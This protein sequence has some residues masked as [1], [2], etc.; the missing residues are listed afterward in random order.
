M[1]LSVAWWVAV[2]DGRVRTGWGAC[3]RAGGEARHW[4]CGGA[5]ASTAPALLGLLG[6]F[7]LSGI[8]DYTCKFKE[9]GLMSVEM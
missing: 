1:G 2:H 5:F 3:S 8:D 4:G 6:V 7:L 9:R